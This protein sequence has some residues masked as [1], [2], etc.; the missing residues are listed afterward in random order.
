[1]YCPKC[2]A[3][4]ESEQKYCR[5]C[6]LPLTILK[7]AL[8]GRV[9]EAVAKYKKGGA[10]L[11]G[12]TFTLGLCLFGALVNLLLIPGP[13][14]VYA[15]VANSIIGLLIALPMIITGHVRLS[16]AKRLLDSED[17]APRLI[18]AESHRTATLLTAPG[19]DPLLSRVPIPSPVTEHTTLNLKSP[20][21]KH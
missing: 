1:M 12:S 13:W 21:R 18:I 2:S 14:N 5:Q 11:S 6:G 9:D 15:V 16:R 17:Q 3:Q 4:N 10:S 8:E 19:T 7:L 20:E